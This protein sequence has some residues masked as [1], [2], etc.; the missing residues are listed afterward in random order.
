MDHKGLKMMF[1]TKRVSLS[2]I[3]NG[4]VTPPPCLYNFAAKREARIWGVSPFTDQIRRV[5]FDLLP[6]RNN[7]ISGE[8]SSLLIFLPSKK[9]AS[10]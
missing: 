2:K 4:K 3:K 7:I 10:E 9:A 6:S 8:K 5:I 1:W